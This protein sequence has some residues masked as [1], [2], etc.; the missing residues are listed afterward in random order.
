MRFKTISI[1]LVVL[2]TLSSVTA[3]LFAANTDIAPSYGFDLSIV[4]DHEVANAYQANLI[5]RDLAS[6]NIVAAPSIRFRSGQPAQA[7]S[8][9]SNGINFEFSIA[10]NENG[11]S[12][13]YNAAVLHANTVVSRSQGKISLKN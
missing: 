8:S 11:S 9:E 2:I 5:I 3:R 1:Y 10:I 6:T 7:K 13:E 12:V 4:P